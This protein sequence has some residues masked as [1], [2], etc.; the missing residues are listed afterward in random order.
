L[1][2][3]QVALTPIDAPERSTR[4]QI[5]WH[6]GVTS[7]LVATRPTSAD[8]FRTPSETI[9]L[10]EELAAGRTDTEIALEL[11]RRGLVNA[12]GRAFTKKGIAW[13]RWKFGIDKPLTDPTVAKS[14]VSPLML[15][16]HQCP[17]RKTGRWNSYHSLL[18]R[19]RN[20]SG[21]PGNS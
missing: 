20:Y 3:K 21:I 15:L 8:R 1:L 19:K 13:I 16:F 18:A 12:R 11:N 2:V 5:L 10:I 9:Q 4:V 6:T 7:I 14:G 17:S